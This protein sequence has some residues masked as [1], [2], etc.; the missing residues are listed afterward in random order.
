MPPRRVGRWRLPRRYVD[1]QELPDAPGVQGQGEVSNAEFREA[2]RILKGVRAFESEGEKKKKKRRKKSL[3]KIVWTFV[4][5]DPYQGNYDSKSYDH[6]RLIH[7]ISQQI[8]GLSIPIYGTDLRTVDRSTVRTGQPSIWS[9]VGLCGTSIYGHDL[10]SR[11]P[12]STAC[13]SLIQLRTPESVVSAELRKPG[14]GFAWGQQW[15]PSASP[16]Q[17]VGSG[18]DIKPANVLLD[19]DMVA[20]VGDFG[21]SKILAI[22]KSMAY[23]KTLGTLGYIAP[24]Y[25]SEGIVSTSGDVYSYIIMLMEVLTKRRPT[26]EEIC[27]GNLN[28][29]KWI[30]QSFSGSMMDVVDANLFSEEEQITSKSEMCIASMI[31]LGLECTKETPESRVT[32][33]DVVKR[34]NKIK[35][36]FLETYK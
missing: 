8:S 24:E 12:R 14:Q 27:N 11:Y 2:I 19:E 3:V 34:L 31:E 18:R 36:V 26:E 4:E 15:S 9:E 6:W 10:R 23:T 32:M 16:A 20:H 1:E 22:S 13:T 28:L 30:T 7:I 17:G 25:G 33:K 29:R 21:I 5:G 35:N